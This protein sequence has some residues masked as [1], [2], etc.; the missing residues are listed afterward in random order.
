MRALA[1]IVVLTCFGSAPGR[2]QATHDSD[3]A[4][5]LVAVEQ[6]GKMQVGKMQAWQNRD[7]KTL[8]AVLDDAF[9]YVDPEG[10]VLTKPEVRLYIETTDSLQFTAEAMTVKLH[11]KTAIVTGI[12]RM[13]GVEHG[14]PFMR[15]G[16][17]VDT[18]LDKNGLWVAIASLLTLAGN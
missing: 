8:N 17:F 18:W 2:A 5:K 11:G 10:K 14:K 6:V 16:R 7:T 13:K 15:R 9:V 1:W 3:V 4:A 12:Y